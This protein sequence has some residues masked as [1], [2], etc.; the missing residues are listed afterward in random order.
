MS[1]VVTPILEAAETEAPLTEWAPNIDVSTPA[2]SSNAFS[3]LATVLEVTALCG[4]MIAM[5]SLFSPPLRD[6]VRLSYSS[7]VSTGQSLGFSGKEGKKNSAIGFPWRDCLA[8]FPGMKATPS[9]LHCF[10]VLSSWERS[11]DLEGR[12]M[13][14][15]KAVFHDS[16]FNGNEVDSPKV[17]MKSRTICTF[18]VPVYLGRGG[19]S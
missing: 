15:R 16:S 7:K 2:A 14:R 6:S 9:R 4:R 18:H 12:V 19:L 13:A 1:L 17:S 3:H 11:A 5:K 10:L 8:R